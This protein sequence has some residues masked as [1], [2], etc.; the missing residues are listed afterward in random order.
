MPKSLKYLALLPNTAK[1]EAELAQ[2]RARVPPEA[3]GIAWA[4]ERLAD[5]RERDAIAATRSEGCWCLGLGG[6]DERTILGGQQYYKKTCVCPEGVAATQT[7]HVLLTAE[8]A[9]QEKCRIDTIWANAHIPARFVDMRLTT[10]PL[11]KTHPE[12]IA[13]L[14]RPHDVFADYEEDPPD[15]VADPYF[16]ALDTW[17][18][19]SYFLYGPFGVGKTGLAVSLARDRVEWSNGEWHER[20]LTSLVFVTAPRMLSELRSTYNRSRDD[21]TPTEQEVIDKYARADLLILDDLGAEQIKNTDWVGDRLYQIIG[22]R[23]DELLPTLFTSN[24]PLDA[25]AKRIGERITWRIVEM[26]GKA[27]IVYLPGPNLRA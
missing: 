14:T 6:E 8:Y 27:N 3:A 18:A 26:V 19:A 25:L 20:F 5:A 2:R 22:E 1:V 24:L 21:D 4:E 12:L 10:S 23:H 15:E 11:A 7:R 9:R 17:W 13:R 16:A